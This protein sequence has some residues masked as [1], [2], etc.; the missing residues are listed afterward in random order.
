MVFGMADAG[1]TCCNTC[2]LLQYY[3][4]KSSDHIFKT[5]LLQAEN[6][7]YDN[8]TIKPNIISC[9]VLPFVSKMVFCHKLTKWHYLWWL[10]WV[11]TM[12]YSVLTSMSS[13]FVQY[14][15]KGHY[16]IAGGHLW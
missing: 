5:I 9:H 13:D 12:A 4:T 1:R 6:G 2:I 8:L 7:N 3:Y 16:Y 11:Y 15:N 10:L 14:T